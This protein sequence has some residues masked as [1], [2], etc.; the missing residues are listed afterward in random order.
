MRR[1]TLPAMNDT[2]NTSWNPARKRATLPCLWTAVKDAFE[3]FLRLLPDLEPDPAGPAVTPRYPRAERHDIR[4]RLDEVEKQARAWIVAQALVFLM[5][6]P[7]GQAMLRTAPRFIQP[8]AKVRRSTI[9]PHP[10]WHTIATHFQRERKKRRDEPDAAPAPELEAEAGPSPVKPRRQRK[11]VLNVLNAVIADGADVSS[12]QNRAQR[13]AHAARQ[14]GKQP[15]RS[16]P[17]AKTKRT[18]ATFEARTGRRVIAL[19]GALENPARLI[20]RTARQL[21]KLAAERLVAIRVAAVRLHR[22]DIQND[23]FADLFWHLAGAYD[24]YIVHLEPG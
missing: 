7:Q 5:M 12:M 9:I 21:V 23:D 20:R 18:G 24:R 8:V 13:R 15:T 3:R 19:E 17:A 6:T 2:T 14:R 22:L 4:E 1:S 11:P 16:A 10:G